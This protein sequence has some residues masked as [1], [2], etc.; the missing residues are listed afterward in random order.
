M[1]K[2][3]KV[4]L[5]LLAI[6]LVAGLA[7]SWIKHPRRT[8]EAF[9]SALSHERYEEAARMLRAPSAIEVA[10]DGA[11]TLVDHG[12]QSTVV[13]REKLPFKV[14]GG[15]PGLG[16]I[17]MTALG[18]STDGILHTPPVVLYLDY[19]GGMTRFGGKIRIVSVGDE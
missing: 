9:L 19:D 4:P 18:P 7:V 11:L 16:E 15:S 12:G 5:A 14:G 10:S 2:H 1:K 13:A 3:A 17:N 6:L 8:R